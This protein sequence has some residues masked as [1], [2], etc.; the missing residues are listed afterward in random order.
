MNDYLSEQHK[1]SGDNPD[2][3]DINEI[4]RAVWKR[5]ISFILPII[6]LLS[7]IL[8]FNALVASKYTAKA[9]LFIDPVGLDITRKN[10][11]PQSQWYIQMC[12][13]QA[14]FGCLHL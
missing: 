6:L 10:I 9:R 11:T 12:L 8:A 4:F 2:L 14:F 1:I 13:H 3:F 5:K 7:G